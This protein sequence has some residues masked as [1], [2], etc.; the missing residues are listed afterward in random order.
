MTDKP[1]IF[2]APM[3]RALLDGR[4]TQTRRVIKLAGRRPEFCGPRGCESDPNCWGWE[5]SEHGDWVTLE[6]EPGQRMCW[7]DWRGAYAPGD[8]L[9][10]REAFYRCEECAHL[11]HA[12]GANSAGIR[13]RKCCA[14]CDELLPRAKSSPIH[15]PRWASRLTLTVTDVRVQRLQEISEADAMAEGIDPNFNRTAWRCYLPEPKAQDYWTSPVE[16]YRTLWNRIHGPGAWDA[17][18]WVAAITFTVERRNIG[19]PTGETRK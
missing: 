19:A 1:I 15:M 10:V 16:G 5:D 3:V 4:K 2:S 18:P 17:N 8:R 14:N 9:W 13:D 11:N 12:E 6:K 7:R